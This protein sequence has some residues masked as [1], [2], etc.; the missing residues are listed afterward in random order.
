MRIVFMGSPEPVVAPLATLVE[1]GSGRGIEVVA[2]VSQPARPVG[3]GGQLKD[4]PLARYAKERGLKVLQPEK[5]KDPLFLEALRDLAPDVVV[6]AAYGQILTAEFLAIPRRAT[7]NIHPSLLPAYRGATPIQA[8]LL[9][10]LETTGISVL[11]TV[12]KLDAGAIIVQEPLAIAPRESAGEL[13]IR[14]FAASGP[15]L[16]KALDLLADPEFRGQPQNEA[17]VTHCKKIAKDDGAIDWQQGADEIINRC[18]AFDPWPGSF[19]FLANRR[20]NIVDIERADEEL[21]TGEPGSFGFDKK[22]QALKVASSDGY[23]LLHRIKPAGGKEQ[24][25]QAFWNGLKDRSGVRFSKHPAG[26]QA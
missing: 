16:L 25:A 17:K 8:A 10:G 20:L 26:E 11:F 6:T 5:A 9:D 12:P 23:V 3:R 22:T 15:L 21:V 14:A 1:Q 13:L 19:T 2:V 7:I 18:R 4:P 24:T